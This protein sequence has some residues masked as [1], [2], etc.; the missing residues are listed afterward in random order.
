M[1]KLKS[2]ILAILLFLC[3]TIV[4]LLLSTQVNSIL[5]EAAPL[6]LT[7]PEI[8]SIDHSLTSAYAEDS[9]FYSWISFEI[10]GANFETGEF[11]AFSLDNGTIWKDFYQ[12]SLLIDQTT[13][14]SSILFKIK[15]SSSDGPVTTYNMP[16]LVD[17]APSVDFILPDAAFYS[18]EAYEVSFNYTPSFV[19]F[20]TTIQL[21]P[22]GDPVAIPFGFNKFLA[23]ENGSYR[24]TTT[25]A[26][27]AVRH[28]DFVVDRIDTTI[29]EFAVFPLASGN[30]GVWAPSVTYVIIPYAIP[31]SGVVYQYSLDNHSWTSSMSD[32][33]SEYVIDIIPEINKPI[34]FRAISGSSVVFDFEPNPDETTKFITCVD[35]V[36]PQLSVELS[37]SKTTPT[38]NPVVLDISSTSGV[39]GVKVFFSTENSSPQEL[40]DG[41]L[42]IYEPGIYRFY[43]VSGAGITSDVVIIDLNH[44]DKTPPEIKG[45]AS[46]AL[47]NENV[48]VGITGAHLVTVKINNKEE[49]LTLSDSDTVTFTKSGNYV[50]TAIDEA[51]NQTQ[52]VFDIEKPNVALTVTLSVVFTGLVLALIFLIIAN[53][54]KAVSI[55]QLIEKTTTSDNNN[56]FLM[57]KRIRKE[58]GGTK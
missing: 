7:S 4:L 24:I 18:Q 29:P 23:S 57:F 17:S 50:L 41:Q 26:T 21:L 5:A 51:G 37:S 54:K 35:S 11:Y 20:S 44:I 48:V 25:S 10:K 31:K 46:G 49:T 40:L 8:V 19:S 2:P 3:V 15:T 55:K 22:D 33:N 34:L 58:K 36:K 32:H 45:V 1:E 28:S 53:Y 6:E 27:G 13:N 47:C 56:K 39:S 52:I 16:V 43:S 38:N 9:A 14:A 12:S 30:D 42:T